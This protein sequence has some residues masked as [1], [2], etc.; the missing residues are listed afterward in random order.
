MSEEV[1][2]PLMS[3]TE[4]AVGVIVTWFVDDGDEVTP[5]TMIAEVAMDKVDAEVH[6]ST[7]GVITVLAAEGSEVVQGS[8]IARVE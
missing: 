8:V 5:Q 1:R 7:S 6:A 4:G 3:T 2:F